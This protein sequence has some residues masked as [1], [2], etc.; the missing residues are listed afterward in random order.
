MYTAPADASAASH[1]ALLGR[2]EDEARA[3]GYGTL[4]LETGEEQP[5]AVALYDSAG[6]TRI[7]P[8]GRYQSDPRSICFRKELG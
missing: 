2:L 4:Q 3:L 1:A 5:E 8:Y 6:W 7:E